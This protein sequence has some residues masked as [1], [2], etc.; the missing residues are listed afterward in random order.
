MG[1]GVGGE[2]G[3]GGGGGVGGVRVDVNEELKFFVKIQKKKNFFFGGGGLGW[4]GGG[5]GQGGCESRI[6]VFWKI[7]KKN[8][9]GGEGGSMGGGPGWGVRMDVLESFHT[10]FGSDQHSIF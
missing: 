9:G 2:V 3:G 1:G 6:E 8:W 4:V 7:Q 10:K 5:G